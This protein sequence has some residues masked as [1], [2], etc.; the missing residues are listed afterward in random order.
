MSDTPRSEPIPLDTPAA[1][2]PNTACRAAENQGP[3]PLN[4]EVHCFR[5]LWIGRLKASAHFAGTARRL[6]P[7]KAQAHDG[8][9]PPDGFDAI[10]PRVVPKC[11][12]WTENGRSRQQ[13][14]HEVVNGN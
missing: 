13:A 8:K 10:N 14:S 3:R 6:G 4:K 5:A 9:G 7:R 2:Q 12:V 1:A 11:T